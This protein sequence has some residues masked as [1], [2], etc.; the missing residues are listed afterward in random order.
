M[1]PPFKDKPTWLKSRGYLHVTP[2]LDILKDYHEIYSRV[3]N[4]DYIRNHGFFPLIHSVIKE[5]KYKK[6]PDNSSQRGHVLNI[7]DKW[8]PSAKLR[9]LHYSTHIDSIIFG[10]YASLIYD[11]Y[12]SDLLDNQKLS[13]CITAYRKIPLSDTEEVSVG[14]STIH[15]ANEAFTEIANRGDDGCVVLM[16]DIKSFFSDLDHKKLKDAWCK[17]F[18]VEKLDEAEFNVFKAVT[19]F[20]YILKDDLRLKS[21]NKRRRAGFDEKK[22]ARI[23]KTLGTDSF[24]ESIN[25]FK[26]ALANRDIKVYK[27]PFYKNKKLVGIPQGLPISAVLANLYLLEFDK[28]VL[29]DVVENKGGFYRRY[30]DDILIICKPEEAEFV[31]QFVTEEIKKSLVKISPTKTEKFL[32]EK[33]QIS[34]KINRLTSFLLKGDEKIQGRS[35]TYL[36]FEFN[37]N[38][39][40]IKSSNLAKFY[41]RMIYLIKRKAK[42]AN[43]LYESGLTENPIIFRGRLI[44]KYKILK[45]DADK[46]H[47]FRKTFTKNDDG[48]FLVGLEKIKV[49]KT[50]KK[51]KEKKYNTTYLTY[52]RKANR[53]M[54]TSP[55]MN[56]IKKHKQIFNMAIH[57]YLKK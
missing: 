3:T 53:I 30:S 55:I 34:E 52:V 35:L 56:Q 48:T 10:Y 27:N 37:G 41:R 31:E 9:P 20:R 4:K 18:G 5:R 1:I 14:K 23:R 45:L 26:K 12:N 49:E 50:D 15:F 17:L 22:L 25:D 2:K 54:Q 13:E 57:K 32:F 29:K 47:R 40:L 8:E 24:F 51:S 6:H 46:Q 16:F 43:R 44:R 11:K 42:L 38:H 39:T 7:N 21:T 33:V 36:G 28:A 19:D